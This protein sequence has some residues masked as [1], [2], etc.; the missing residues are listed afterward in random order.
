MRVK[1]KKWLKTNYIKNK[2]KVNIG[3]RNKIQKLALETP[4]RYD[5]GYL[6]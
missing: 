6:T 2:K 1:G 3:K 5:K 4:R